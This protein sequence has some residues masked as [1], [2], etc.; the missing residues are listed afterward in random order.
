MNKV[1]DLNTMYASN[2]TLDGQIHVTALAQAGSS[3]RALTRMAARGST[4]V[5]PLKFTEHDHLDLLGVM[6]VW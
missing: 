5:S 1:F 6:T 2:A 3:R 4:M